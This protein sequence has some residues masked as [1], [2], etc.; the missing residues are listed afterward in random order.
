MTQVNC[1]D[2]KPGMIVKIVDEFAPDATTG[3]LISPKNL[4]ARRCGAE[5]TVL[6][7]VAGH[8][9]DVWWVEHRDG[10]VAAYCFTEIERFG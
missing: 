7:F 9:G 5:G 3:M 4:A 2:V 10:S 6:G 8:G 1:D